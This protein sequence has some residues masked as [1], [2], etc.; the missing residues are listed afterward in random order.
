MPEDNGHCSTCQIYDNA[1]NCIYIQSFKE[2]IGSKISDNETYIK[3]NSLKPSITQ[4]STYSTEEIWDKFKDI[5]TAIK[6]Y[7][8]LGDRNPTSSEV[9]ATDVT[10]N[11]YTLLY[12]YNNILTALDKNEIS[13]SN[14]I[15]KTLIDNLKT[16]IDDYQLDENRC[17][18][19]NT[20]GNCPGCQSQCSDYCSGDC[21]SC[22]SSCDASLGACAFQCQEDD[23][24]TCEYRNEDCTSNMQMC[25][26]DD[27]SYYCQS[28]DG[29]GSGEGGGCSDSGSC[30]LGINNCGGNLDCDWSD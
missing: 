26:T 21:L 15:S 6:D 12:N 30:G 5:L 17:N 2:T 16:Y 20:S 29:C 28:G 24:V 14:F 13:G 22:L 25:G 1:S 4:N 3:I 8:E 27:C 11:N 9:N 19:C 7:G 10:K 23:S 18:I